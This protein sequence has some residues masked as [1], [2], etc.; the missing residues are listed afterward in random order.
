MSPSQARGVGGNVSQRDTVHLILR[1][2]SSATTDRRPDGCHRTTKANIRSRLY[3]GPQGRNPHSFGLQCTT[4]AGINPSKWTEVERRPNPTASNR[5]VSFASHPNTLIHLRAS[6]RP[7]PRNARSGP[8]R[9]E[10]LPATTTSRPNVLLH[11]RAS[12]SGRRRVSISLRP[13]YFNPSTLLHLRASDRDRRQRV[14]GTATGRPRV[15]ESASATFAFH[16]MAG[17]HKRP[18]NRTDFVMRF[19]ART[20]PVS[21]PSQW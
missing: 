21:P 4:F 2:P 9:R 17:K 7:E 10:S 12:D 3:G 19:H 14:R 16:R 20:V 13:A 8:G 18:S 6:E 5:S 1:G 15:T 11:L